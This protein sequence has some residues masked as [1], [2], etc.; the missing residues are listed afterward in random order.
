MFQTRLLQKMDR[1]L[2]KMVCLGLMC[3]AGLRGVQVVQREEFGL[4][5]AVPEYTCTVEIKEK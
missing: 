1:N 2:Q 3:L 4:R 5:I